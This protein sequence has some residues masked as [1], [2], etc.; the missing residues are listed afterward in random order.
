M[1]ANQSFDLGLDAKARFEIL[2]DA[3]KDAYKEF[4]DSG[5]KILGVLLIVLGWFAG[6]KNPLAMLCEFT[7]LAHAALVFTASGQILLA[8]LFGILYLRAKAV[9]TE[10]KQSNCDEKLFQRYRVTPGMFACIV[11]GQFTMLIG[12]FTL[13]YTRYVGKGNVCGI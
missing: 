8:Y 1:N 3:L 7:T 12:I 9:Y 6:Q 2:H 5:L 11:F 4:I 13:L 10:L